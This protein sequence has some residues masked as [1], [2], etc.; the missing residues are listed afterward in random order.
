MEEESRADGS[1]DQYWVNGSI[2]STTTVEQ[3]Q[4]PILKFLMNIFDSSWEDS[5][6]G[7]IELSVRLC[8]GPPDPDSTGCQVSVWDLESLQIWNQMNNVL[9]LANFVIE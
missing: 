4:R 3:Q 6:Q 5:S 1:I 2:A 9:D 8:C 7:D